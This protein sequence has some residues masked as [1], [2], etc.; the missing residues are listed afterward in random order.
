ME[1]TDV[2]NK[3]ILLVFVRYIFQED[4]HED[5]CLLFLPTNTTAAELY[6]SLNDY[7]SG[8]FVSVYAQMEQLQCMDGAAVMT[9]RISGLTTKIKKLSPKRETTLCVIHR[10]MRASRKMSPELNSILQDGIKVIK[11]SPCP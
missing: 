5:L 11:Q 1:Y 6:K 8:H 3:A 7:I 9:G 2:A 10:E 4:G